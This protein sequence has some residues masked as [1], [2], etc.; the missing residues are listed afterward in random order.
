MSNDAAITRLKQQLEL[1]A[2]MEDGNGASNADITAAVIQRMFEA[3]SLDAAMEAQDASLPS[4]KS[5]SDTEMTVLGIAVRKADSKYSEHS[6]GYYLVVDAAR[7]D[8]GAEMRFAVG[9]PN[10]VA[11]LFRAL[12]EGMLPLE[13]VIRSRETANGELLSLRRI[14]RRAAS[15]QS[16]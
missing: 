4:G 7:L 3:D 9:A 16:G 5:I 8:T 2:S 10:V 15:V 13:C 12:N 11:L 1:A 6:L 14:P